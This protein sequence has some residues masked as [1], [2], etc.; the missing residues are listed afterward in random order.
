M[1]CAIFTFIAL[2]SLGC[3]R[4]QAP[5]KSSMVITA[6]MQVLDEVRSPN[7]RK[8]SEEV[9]PYLQMGPYDCSFVLGKME[10]DLEYKYV[11]NEAGR[12]KEY[13]RYLPEGPLIYSY[14]KLQNDPQYFSSIGGDQVYATFL[15]GTRQVI[16]DG[17]TLD[18]E[19]IFPEEKVIMTQRTPEQ[20]NS[21]RRLLF[22]YR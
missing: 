10:F 7:H 21:G 15:P 2:L 17:D 19:R 5:I 9:K 14:E 1:K 6:R 22:T 8:C 18:I 13:W 16:A 3:I 12:L 20:K 4:P 11:L